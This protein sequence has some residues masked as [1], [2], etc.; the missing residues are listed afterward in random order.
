MSEAAKWWPNI[1]VV[2]DQSGNRCQWPHWICSRK[3]YHYS[4]STWNCFNSDHI[5]NASQLTT[6]TRKVYTDN[7]KLSRE[8][9]EEMVLGFIWNVY[10]YNIF[11]IIINVVLSSLHLQVHLA[12]LFLVTERWLRLLGSVRIETIGFWF[13]W[14]I[15]K[16]QWFWIL[17][18]DRLT[19]GKHCEEK[20]AWEINI[21]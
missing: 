11:Y 9:K 6:K 1:Y 5:L 4:H 19:Y 10:N 3:V 20:K 16:H 21:P 13:S 14:G 18:A 12:I 7:K 15:F 8:N 2:D 17:E